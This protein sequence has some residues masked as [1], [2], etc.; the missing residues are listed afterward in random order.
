MGGGAAMRAGGKLAGVVNASFRGGI[1]A[2]AVPEHLSSKARPIAGVLSSSDAQI[3]ASTV[4][5]VCSEC[6]DDWEFP[7]VEEAMPR[8]VFGGPPS[9]QEAQ[10]A[11]SQLR[12]ALDEA[13]LSNKSSCGPYVSYPEHPLETKVCVATD[14]DTN[15]SARSHAIQAFRLL[16]ESTAAQTVVASIASD[17]NVWSAVLQND[18]LVEFL[19]SQ[20]T[21]MNGYSKKSSAGA[22][23]SGYDSDSAKK[24][25]Y[26]T[27]D[28]E[29]RPK[30]DHRN[31]LEDIRVR[32]EDMMNS[33]SGFF[34]NLF[35]GS[36]TVD[37]SAKATSVDKAMGASIMGLAIMVILI[38]VLRR[39]S[40]A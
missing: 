39:G 26:E 3:D 11:T 35:A 8:L 13:Y 2:V 1:P 30:N 19:R 31:F 9:L 17:Q 4:N 29:T 12:T 23:H 38:V 33:L 18:A 27:S 5:K 24:F 37:G 40:T 32:L 22:E 6:D 10:D 20:K 21:G 28:E 7:Q 14:S 15:A 36:G 16:N 25:D 34:Q